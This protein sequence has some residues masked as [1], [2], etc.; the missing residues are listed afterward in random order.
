MGSTWASLKTLKAIE[1]PYLAK[2]APL[3]IASLAP[4][5]E[6]SMTFLGLAELMGGKEQTVEKLNAQFETAQALAFTSGNSHDRERDPKYRRIPINYGNQ[7]SIQTAFVFNQ[8]DRPDLT[9]YWARK[10]VETAFS[11]LSPST[12]YNGDEDQGLMGS[13]AVLMKMGLFM[14]NSIIG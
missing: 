7:P 14:L 5:R 12:G 13:L 3:S 11:G 9:Q 1:E 4:L 8:L 2:A 10:V 6:I